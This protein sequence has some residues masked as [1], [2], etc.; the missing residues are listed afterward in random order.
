MIKATFGAKRR[1]NAFHAFLL[2]ELVLPAL[3]MEKNVLNAS[4]E[5]FLKSSVKAVSKNLIIVLNMEEM[6]RMS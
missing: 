6:K 2:M 1:L 3:D 4:M 5:R